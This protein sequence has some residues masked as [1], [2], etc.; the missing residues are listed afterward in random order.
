MRELPTGTVT[1]LFTDIEGSTRLLQELGPDYS[2]VQTDHMRIMREAIAEG[3]GQEIRTEGDAFFAVFPTATGAVLATVRAQR[4]M[5]NH[6]WS[7][8]RALRV[9]IGVHT[10]EGRLGGDDYLGIDV[11]RAARIAAAGH[12]GQVLLSEATRTLVRDSLPEGVAVRDLGAHRL[13]DLAE[14]EHLYDLRID[15]LLAEFP[16]LK[17]LETPTNLPAELTSFVGR[18]RELETVKRLLA[19]IR[20]LTLTGPG[21]S[22]KTRLAL[23]AAS[24]L[25]DR[26]PDGV[27]FVELAS[28]SDPN[29]VPSEIASALRTGELG[30]RPVL[31][32]LQIELRH[33]KCLLVLDNFEQVVEA[34]PSVGALIASAPLIRVLVTSRAPLRIGGEQEFPVSPLELPDPERRPSPDELTRFEALTLFVERAMAVD[35]SFALDEDNSRAVVEICRRLDGLPLAI[36]L[37][38]SRL[39]LL[40]PSALL[41]RLDRGLRLLASSSRDVPSRQRTLRAAIEWSYNLLAPEIATLFR[42]ICVFAGGFTIAAAESV[43]D[44]EDELGIDILD[45]LDALLDTSLVRRRPVMVDQDRFETLQTVRAY[46]LERLQEQEEA[47][48]MRRRHALYFLEFAET[49]EPELRGPDLDLHLEVLRLEHDNMRTALSWAIEHDEGEVS[50]RL[51]AALWRFWQ[52][53]GHLTAG[54]R[55][56]EQALSL[57]SAAGRTRVRARALLAAGSLAYWQHAGPPMLKAYEEGLTI[58]RELEDPAGIAL[59]TFDIGF[60]LALDG[61]ILE[62]AETFGES[63]SLFEEVG[64][65]RGVG[66]SLFALSGMSRKLGDFAAARAHAEEALRLHKE[67]GDVFGIHGDLYVLARAAD[68]AGDLETAR[69]LFIETM[70]MAWHVGF[71]TGIALSL[72][73]LANQETTRGRPIRA[74]R[75]AGAS[76]T[77]KES[78]G[79]EAPPEL[80][81]LPDTRGKARLLIGEEELQAAWDEGRAMSLE[82]ALAYAREDG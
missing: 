27:F 55:W 72:D 49:T 13:K 15:G 1:F 37:A 81:D 34:S 30:R 17:S 75:L 29:L 60:V 64:D 48:A 62:A 23:R 70:D 20:L 22:G 25:L 21:G 44:P 3:G 42:R 26:F 11:N 79:G 46:G 16:P 8:G 76:E 47:P 19:S 57:P 5:H 67:L 4:A 10:G 14:P 2:R 39:R 71:P 63:R 18:E 51:V 28:I 69:D 58:F 31:E 77:I 43:S 41:E 74:M 73:L 45:G 40:S 82:E 56:A 66:D 32:T 65:T 6:P 53:H 9:R 38:A 59:A 80:L 12:G 68:A 50:L 33:R 36:E 54:R 35:P 61:K 24:D 78:V 7:H 52:I